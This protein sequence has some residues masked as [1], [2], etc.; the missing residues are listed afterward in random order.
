MA[1]LYDLAGALPYPG[2]RPIRLKLAM[3]IGGEYGLRNIS[4]R[5]WQRFAT[6]AHQTPEEVLAN[7][8][9]AAKAMPDH[10]TVIQKRANSQGL[11]YPIIGRLSKNLIARAKKR[12]RLLK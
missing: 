1:P 8:R 9:K 7:L 3:K 11:V 10:V 4:A 6:E 2:M 12:Q 5:H